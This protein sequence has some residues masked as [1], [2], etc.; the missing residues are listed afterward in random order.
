MRGAPS[1]TAKDNGAWR[2]RE[3][4]DAGKI[5]VVGILTDFDPSGECIYST[6]MRDLRA[7]GPQL[8]DGSSISPCEFR[9]LAIIDDDIKK[10]GLPL[11]DIDPDKQKRDRN[12]PAFIERYGAVFCELDALHPDQLQSIVEAFILDHLD[13]RAYEAVKTEEDR[14][15]AQYEEKL[16]ESR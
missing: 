11:N 2:L 15:R 4:W 10:Y 16:N 8:A 9:K 5:P 3:A 6:V 14:Q 7:K 12:A 13:L 1:I